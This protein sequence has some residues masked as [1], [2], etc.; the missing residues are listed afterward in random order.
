MSSQ[1]RECP[2]TDCITSPCPRQ[3]VPLTKD[4]FCIYYNN[5]KTRAAIEKK[6]VGGKQK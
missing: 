1:G 2:K 6:R 3:R 4:T 5:G